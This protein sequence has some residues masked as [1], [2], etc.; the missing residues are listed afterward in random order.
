MT[1]EHKLTVG[2]GD[3]KAIVF[4]CAHNGCIARAVVSPDHFKIPE[5]CP[6]CGG[7][8]VKQSGLSEVTITSST[9]TNFVQHIGTI[10]AR[11]AAAAEDANEGPKFRILL[12]FDEP[13]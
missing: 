10:R 1:V 9:Y 6:G 5:H 2:L 4:A 7:L 11:E 13:K 8:W 3:L 12:Q